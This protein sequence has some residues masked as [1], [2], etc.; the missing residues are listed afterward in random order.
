LEPQSLQ[1]STHIAFNKHQRQ[2]QRQ[3]PHQQDE[4]AALIYK[5]TA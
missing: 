4:I 3:Q 5:E 1:A 2:Q